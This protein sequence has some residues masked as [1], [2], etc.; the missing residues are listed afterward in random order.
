MLQCWEYEP[1]NRP[2]FKDCLSQ[3]ETLSQMYDIHDPDHHHERNLSNDHFA[4]EYDN[5]SGMSSDS[6][7]DLTLGY[8]L[9]RFSEI[10]LRWYKVNSGPSPFLRQ[11]LCFCAWSS[12]QPKNLL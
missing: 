11:R 6:N 7:F 3:L 5:Q 1:E 9:H 12:P 8:T 2:S 4:Q 10:S